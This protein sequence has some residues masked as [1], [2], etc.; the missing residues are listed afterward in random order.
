MKSLIAALVLALISISA[1]AQQPPIPNCITNITVI[2]TDPNAT[3]NGGGSQT[4]PPLGGTVTINYNP[5]YCPTTNVTIGVVV[6]DCDTHIECGINEGGSG[7]KCPPG[8]AK[9][10]EMYA[11]MG[12][13]D[14]HIYT[15]FGCCSFTF[16]YGNMKAC[17]PFQ[18]SFGS[19]NA[20]IARVEK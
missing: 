9:T 1:F 17:Q 20:V 15:V 19:T 12:T 13:E 3:F 11:G 10:I 2:L 14:L 5:T 8:Y 18:C 4:N 6:I 7:S 16:S